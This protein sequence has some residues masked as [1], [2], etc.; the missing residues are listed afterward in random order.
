MSIVPR[1]GNLA[2]NVSVKIDSHYAVNGAFLMAQNERVLLQCI[3]YKEM[4]LIPGSGRSPGGG[5]SN[6]PQCS[7]LGKPMDREAWWATVH[8]VARVKYD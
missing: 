8:G 6:S 5:N 3:R 4:G 2:L 7:C 1:L